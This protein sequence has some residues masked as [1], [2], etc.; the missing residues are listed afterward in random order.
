MTKAEAIEFLAALKENV[1]GLPSFAGKAP[2]IK[3][4]ARD[5]LFLHN[6]QFDDNV[7]QLICDE[8]Q[9]EWQRLNLKYR[10]PQSRK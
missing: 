1:K 8:R 7:P 10:T 5:I 6:H 3:K 9:E 4:L 2:F